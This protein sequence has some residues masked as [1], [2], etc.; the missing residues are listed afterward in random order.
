MEMNKKAQF[1]TLVQTWAI[2][3]GTSAVSSQRKS[4]EAACREW[5]SVVDSAMRI[6]EE[7]IPENLQE[8]CEQFMDCLTAGDLD[9]VPESNW[10]KK[11]LME[12]EEA[13]LR[14]KSYPE[15]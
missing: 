9:Q 15:P 3:M 6:P 11:I 2:I 4:T 8:A 14:K 7:A 1:V 10:V 13:R 12:K 5:T